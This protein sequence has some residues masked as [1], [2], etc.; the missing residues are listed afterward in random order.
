M[1]STNPDR[2]FDHAT[3]SI[4]RN[5]GP[6]AR[7]PNLILIAIVFLLIAWIV[8]DR[9]R[10]FPN[11]PTPPLNPQA[12]ARP[13]A[14]AG[15]LAEDE[16]STIDLFR[17]CSKSVVFIST[18]EVGRDFNFNVTEIAKGTGSGF[19][20]DESGHVVTN[21]HVVEGADRWRVTL[22]D[23]T[24]WNATPIGVAPD[25]DLA[26]LKIDAPPQHLSPILVGSSA[27][28]EVGQKV[29]A[30]G[31]PFGLDQTL[32]TGIISGLGRQIRSQTGRNI[33]GVIQTDAAI[34]PGNS[35]GPLL[36]SHGRLIG[37]NAAIFSPSGTSAGIGFAIPV[38]T[39]NRIVP[40]LLRHGKVIRPGLGASYMPDRITARLGLKGV[41]IGAVKPGSPAEVA[42]ILPVSRDQVGDVLLGDLLV[43]VD[44]KPINTVEE[45]FNT[46]DRHEI[47]DE[48][49]LTL[50][51][52]PLTNAET[53][54]T[55]KV[56]LQAAE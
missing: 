30:I 17:R 29:F 20:W 1:D 47:G 8:S 50:K 39:V 32:T 18:A 56:K 14:P 38:D 52:H 4:G 26:V 15:D 28:L 13:V 19:L 37:V 22:A 31:N 24:T 53:N 43:A 33:D 5:T 44:G 16:R 41:L 6:A 23:Q 36:D 12:T 42:G 45:L 10:R 25:K 51:R 11:T 27:Q 9:F 55:V 21:F 40:Q 3:H 54:L 48:V 46:L 49:S 7:S 34:N 2:R 35:G